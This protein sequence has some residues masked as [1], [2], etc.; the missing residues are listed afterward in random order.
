M[1]KQGKYQMKKN[2]QH[3]EI[4]DNVLGKMKHTYKT[5]LLPLEESSKFHEFHSSPL[6]EA[7]FTA[8]PMILL[9]GHFSSGKTTFIKYLLESDFPGI[10]I[11]PEPTTDKF[12]AIMHGKN[13]GVVPGNALVVDDTKQFKPLSKFGN[14]FLNRFQCSQMDNPV[15]ESL[16]I[17]DT[18]G[19]L[20]GQ[21]QKV[22][23]GYDFTS[24]V[25]WFAERCCRIILLFAAHGLDISDEYAELLSR[26]RGYDEKIR[27]V[28]NKADSVDHQSMMRVYG[29]LMWSLGK[30][31]NTPEVARVYI[32]SFWDNPLHFDHSRKLFELEEQDLMNDIQTLPRNVALRKLNDIVKRARLTKVHAYIIMH[33]KSQM[34]AVFGKD[35]K[36]KELIENLQTIFETIQRE[37]S[38]S[39]GDF[40]D[41]EA[42]KE[43][44][45]KQDFTTFTTVS[46]NNLKKIDE[47]LSND[48]AQLMQMIPMDDT[49]EENN[50]VLG[51]AFVKQ[52][53]TPFKYGAMEGL[54]FG[55]GEE[56]WVVE[57]VRYKYDEIFQSLYPTNGKISGTTAKNQ[58]TKSKLPNIVLGKIWRLADINR[59][60]QMDDDEFALAMYLIDLKLDGNEIPTKLPDHLIPPSY[61]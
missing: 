6:T 19:I 32:G 11:G 15:L 27:I 3:G 41:V 42:M 51:G 24:V 49:S 17:V 53:E 21:K 56:D 30:V 1:G 10:R 8:K 43:K 57:R 9:I 55:R 2:K 58:M 16:S 26:L 28:L 31:L 20:S 29:A 38:I 13:E 22:D 44:L 39:P 59:D 25:E 14:A 37:K 34:P 60:G 5:V 52:S 35:A 48:V 4:I 7:E 45:R 40:P 23:R 36:K 47:M 12:I 46:Q 18:P 33:I 50:I 54:D 61:R